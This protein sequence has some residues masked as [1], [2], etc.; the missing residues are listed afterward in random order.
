MYEPDWML[1][2]SLKVHLPK[3]GL[4]FHALLLE[5]PNIYQI[6]FRFQSSLLPLAHQFYLSIIPVH[7]DWWKQKKECEDQRLYH[8]RKGHLYEHYQESNSDE[9]VYGC[10]FP[11]IH[12]FLHQSS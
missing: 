4:L 12:Q 8:K 11:K 7:V 10:W 9:E 3:L 5:E 2:A 6:R 1:C